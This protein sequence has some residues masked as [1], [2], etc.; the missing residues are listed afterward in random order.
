MKRFPEA[1]W[2][3][4]GFLV[5]LTGNRFQQK[6]RCHRAAELVHPSNIRI[7]ATSPEGHLSRWGGVGSFMDPVSAG[8]VHV[9]GVRF[10]NVR[11][12]LCVRIP[13][14]PGATWRY[15]VVWQ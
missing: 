13:A 15:V 10:G 14:L 5:S 3:S 6:H 8:G 4:L 1:G 11:V 9:G 12:D 2:K 7:F